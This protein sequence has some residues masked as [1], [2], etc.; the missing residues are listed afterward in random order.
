MKTEK[1][2]EIYVP[3]DFLYVLQKKFP[4]E[5]GSKRLCEK[6][7]RGGYDAEQDGLFSFGGGYGRKEFCGMLCEK[8]SDCCTCKVHENIVDIGCAQGEKL[9]KLNAEGDAEGEQER[10]AERVT[11]IPEQ[12]EKQPQRDEQQDIQAGIFEIGRDACKGDEVQRDIQAVVED[13]RKADQCQNCGKIKAEE[14]GT[15]NLHMAVCGK[16]SV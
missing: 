2:D 14:D 8:I 13:A 10:A 15:E 4:E 3:S 1:S 7:Y 5:G 11:G 9:R 16:F 12:G 6:E